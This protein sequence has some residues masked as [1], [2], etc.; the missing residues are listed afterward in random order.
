MLLSIN[1]DINDYSFISIVLILT[2]QFFVMIDDQEN[3]WVLVTT[4]HDDIKV[5]IF[6][7]EGKIFH[8]YLL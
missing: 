6:K 3:Y 1:S 7:K 8:T 4:V 5:S 2:A